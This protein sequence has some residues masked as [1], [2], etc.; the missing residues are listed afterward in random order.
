[1]SNAFD[2]DQG[3]I[4]PKPPKL[5]E[6]L[7][8]KIR[9]QRAGK[10]KYNRLKGKKTPEGDAEMTDTAEVLKELYKGGPQ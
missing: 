2:T 4:G 6:S 1:M 9:N 8:K 10:N 5:S 7:K 3:G